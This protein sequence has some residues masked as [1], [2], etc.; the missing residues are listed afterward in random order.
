VSNYINDNNL[1]MDNM[2]RIYRPNIKM[3]KR[4]LITAK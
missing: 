3:T 2:P 1:L 4:K